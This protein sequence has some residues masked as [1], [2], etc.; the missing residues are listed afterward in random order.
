MSG[1][2]KARLAINL[3]Q[4]LSNAGGKWLIPP[5]LEGNAAIPGAA[6]HGKISL[7]E[8][9]ALDTNNSLRRRGLALVAS[10]S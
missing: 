1:N 7:W 2:E 4:E 8:N 6:L 5:K 10:V 9:C 3:G